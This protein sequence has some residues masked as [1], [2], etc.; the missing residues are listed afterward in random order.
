MQSLG[1]RSRKTAWME[2]FTPASTKLLDLLRSIDTCSIS[3]AIETLNVRMRNDGY[4]QQSLSC[5]LPAHPPVAGYAVTGRIRT[6]APPISRLCYYQRPD[7]WGYI[8]KLP[9]PKIM[10]IEDMDTSPG[11]G[12][13]VGEIHAEICRALGCVAYVTNGAIRDLPALE[14]D[15]FQCFHRTVC[16]SHAYAH[17]VD[18][19]EP[20]V[21]GGLKI[22]PG[23]LL[24][25]DRHGVQ[26]VPRGFDAQI[27]AAVRDIQIHESE[28]IRL[29]R[30]PGFTVQ[31]LAEMLRKDVTCPLPDRR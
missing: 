16:P 25:G 20:V 1:H 11:C 29:C 4:V 21:I 15:N 7:W 31:R 13:L 28:L 14:R 8:A 23:D 24:H 30:S 12:A 17:I 5:L 2:D 26:S 6:A 22:A 3:N 9:S 18:F 27:H 19:G 10:V